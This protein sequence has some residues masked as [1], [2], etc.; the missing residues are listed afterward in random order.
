[1][2]IDN[3]IDSA[4]PIVEVS[5][6]QYPVPYVKEEYKASGNEYLFVKAHLEGAVDKAAIL[7]GA[8]GIGKTFMIA[9][10]C[11]EK[12][13]NLI[14]LD[15]N[16]DIKRFDVTGRFSFR[17][18]TVTYITGVMATAI[19]IA[20]KT[21][22]ACLVLEEINAL[23]PN[24]QVA[25]NSLT[26]FRKIVNIPDINVTFRLKKGAKLS[27]FA[28]MNPNYAGTYDLNQAVYS[29]FAEFKCDYPTEIVE[30]EIIKQFA[31]NNVGQ[32]YINALVH[33]AKLTRKGVESASYSYA[34]S[35]RDLVSFVLC[36]NG[37]LN[38]PSVMNAG[39]KEKAWE[40][41]CQ[42]TLLCRYQIKTELE[43]FEKQLE[44]AL[45]EYQE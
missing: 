11:Q 32:K 33:L 4:V 10:A 36:F 26:D 40:L 39:G 37:Y 15:C 1:M 42:S 21:G 22:H 17:G 20:N 31:N 16:S 35:P 45:G 14:Q 9:K 8:A 27:V 34:L 41:A 7:S 6:D 30:R 3:T 19:R 43:T 5:A 2:T 23:R 29:R 25:L 28:T 13:V 44:S 38:S 18:D 24:I 12:N